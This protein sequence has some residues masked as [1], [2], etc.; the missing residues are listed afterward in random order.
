METDMATLRSVNTH[1]WRDAYI[2]ELSPEAKLLFLYLLTAPD[3]TIAGAYECTVRMMAFDTGLQ[4]SAVL[5]VLDQ[6][7]EAGK[8]FYIDGYVVLPNH[9]K[10]QQLN[11]NMEV[12]RRKL[13]AKLPVKVREAL[14]SPAESFPNRSETIP[15]SLPNRSAQLNRIELNG[16]EEVET[17]AEKLASRKEKFSKEIF[18]DANVAK[19]GRPMLVKFFDYWGEETRSGA[20]MRYDLQPTWKLAG[21]LATW[22]SRELKNKGSGKP[23]RLNYTED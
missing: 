12:A 20:K 11:A 13:L 3:S 4:P 22:A 7:A 16:I 15:E 6:L 14:E 10:N 2:C 9:H 1:F 17:P 21:R 18:S 8:A 23:S 19:Y 5:G